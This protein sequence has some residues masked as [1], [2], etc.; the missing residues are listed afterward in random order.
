MQQI[1]FMNELEILDSQTIGDL[2]SIFSAHLDSPTNNTVY[3]NQESH[4]TIS[5]WVITKTNCGK[6][7]IVVKKLLGEIE[8]IPLTINR[9]DVRLRVLQCDS[10]LELIC[11]FNR[12]ILLDHSCELEIRIDGKDYPWKKINLKTIDS[13][14]IA[15]AKSVWNNFLN[16]NIQIND[17]HLRF[18]RMDQSALDTI[19][20]PIKICNRIE[21]FLSCTEGM[22][23][24][25]FAN[26]FFEEVYSTNLA[27]KLV[28]AALNLGRSE[29]INPFSCRIAS[30]TESYLINNF[31]NALIF[32][33]VDE[34]FIVLQ[35]VTSADA[36]YCPKRNILVIKSHHLPEEIAVSIRDWLTKNIEKFT[37]QH[38][39]RRSFGGIISSHGRPYHFY[40]DVAPAVEALYKNGLLDKVPGIFLLEGGDFISLKALYCLAASEQVI[41]Y[42]NLNSD[43][44]LFNRFLIKVG[45]Q[46]NPKNSSLNEEFDKRLLLHVPNKLS[47][48][49]RNQI[50]AAKRC[51]PLIWIGITGQKRSWCEQVDAGVYLINELYRA[52]PGLG[53]CFDGWTS[54]LN[55]T[56]GDSIEVD[57]DQNITSQ[58]QA[59][60]PYSIPIFNLV[61]ETSIHKIGFA[62]I[63]D[64]FITNYLTGSIH[65][66]RFAKKPGLGHISNAMSTHEGH[67]HFRT[68]KIPKKY[69]TDVETEKDR[70]V[71]F[72][73]YHISPEAIADLTFK[74]MLEINLIQE[75]FLT[76]GLNM[77]S[78]ESINIYKNIL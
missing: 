39:L 30:C 25:S 33:D 32:R 22:I 62:H 34:F 40:Y 18:V 15:E 29:L 20:G 44:A 36:I 19:L 66:S 46:F 9:P 37:S 21:Q 10:D 38:I 57:K 14:W 2:Q 73:S 27:S 35:H 71:D 56:L 78:N 60:I 45:A 41:S 28:T 64:F 5:G 48:D 59:K 6:I 53:I 13:S 58:I 75:R 61:G 12:E 17:E 77:P 49:I 4:I 65:V 68:I 54:P 3:G 76:S 63:V 11:G 1:K 43:N 55:R 16:L 24:E 67:T 8:L 52:F 7:S 74:M 72:I 31:M 26:I 23:N 51:F 50:I 69:V 47:P 70:R 42:E